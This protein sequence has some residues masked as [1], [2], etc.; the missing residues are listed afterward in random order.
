LW[1]GRW[2]LATRSS[3]APIPSLNAASTSITPLLLIEIAKAEGAERAGRKG[4]DRCML[5]YDL[6]Y[7]SM[8]KG[9]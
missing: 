1:G 7:A 4:D 5:R 9:K 6:A 2:T 3:A 8:F